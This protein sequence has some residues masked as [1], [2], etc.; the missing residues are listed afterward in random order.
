[1]V[2]LT[3]GEDA[4]ALLSLVYTGE[5]E[6]GSREE[7]GGLWL[8]AQEL[9]LGGG[10]SLAKSRAR[11]VEEQGQGAV[12]HIVLG[13]EQQ[14]EE[15]KCDG[16]P[17]H[18]DTLPEQIKVE[19]TKVRIVKRTRE[20][21]AYM[22]CGECGGR[23]MTETNLRSHIA[24][25]HSVVRCGECGQQCRGSTRLVDHV[26]TVHSEGAVVKQQYGTP[27]CS[28]CQ[29]IFV[30]NQ[31]LKF[32]LYKH[33][34]LKPFK[35]KICLASFRTPSTL[36]SHVEVQHTESK[37]RCEICGLKSSTSGKLKIHMRTHTNEKP[38]Q[39][40]FCP[41]SFKQL[42]VLRVHEFTH[43]KKSSYKC[44][45]CGNYFP[46]KNRLI[47]HKSKPVCISRTRAPP[48]LRRLRAS[49]S[50]RPGLEQE[51]V[52]Q[53]V[54]YLIRQDAVQELQ[55]LGQETQEVRQEFEEP[56]AMSSYEQGEE[57]GSLETG[58]IFHYS[59][60]FCFLLVLPLL[61][62]GRYQS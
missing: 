3:G 47:I 62:Q 37:H 2:V 35:C 51:L 16:D 39:C 29:E 58:E 50:R 15:I 9:G 36:K 60:F 30:T 4:T 25:V 48:G 34:G 38:Y 20:A 43:T 52:Q 31:A 23:F 7:S 55:D 56:G 17:P 28:L 8:L 22:E 54:T 26:A 42:S 11:V 1:M 18:V 33:S 27:T 10:I 14:E 12:T 21:E 45:K 49:R 24:D 32:H 19:K 40:T 53:G 46:T 6:C 57:L 44:D 5:A 13:V 61:P 41:T 59:C